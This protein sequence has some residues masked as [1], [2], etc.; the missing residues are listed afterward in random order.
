[1]N[2]STLIDALPYVDKE[3]SNPLMKKKV[4]NLVAKEMNK[5]KKEKMFSVSDYLDKYPQLV[6]QLTPTLQNEMKRMENKQQM[7]KMEF[8]ETMNEETLYKGEY[9]SIKHQNLQLYAKYGSDALQQQNES[10][11]KILTK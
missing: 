1:M 7:D 5:M 8:D 9:I 6:T 10:L 4:D 3:Y 2:D 11:E